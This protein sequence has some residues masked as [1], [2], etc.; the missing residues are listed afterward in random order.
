MII[1]YIYIYIYIYILIYLYIYYIH[2]CVYTYISKID[3]NIVY[4]I[5]IYI[6]IYI[7]QL[8]KGAGNSKKSIMAKLHYTAKSYTI[9]L[10]QVMKHRNLIFSCIIKLY[11]YKFLIFPDPFSSCCRQVGM[12]ACMHV[13]MY[14]C[15]Y[16]CIYVQVCIHTNNKFVCLS[17]KIT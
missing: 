5:Y 6:Y 1:I 9:K 10:L 13:C 4:S 7:Q 17:S 16:V 14:V 8:L 2:I 11:Q 3:I 12:H 15:M